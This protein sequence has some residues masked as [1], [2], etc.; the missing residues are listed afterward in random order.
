M[1]LNISIKAMDLP[2]ASWNAMTVSWSIL[3]N[4]LLSVCH[5]SILGYLLNFTALLIKSSSLSSIVQQL[6]T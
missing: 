2:D 1:D 6:D 4:M 3:Q 5:A